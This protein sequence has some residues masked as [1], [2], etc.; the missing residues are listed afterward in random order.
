MAESNHL[1]GSQYTQTTLKEARRI[2]GTTANGMTDESITK[3]VAQIDVL[4][5]I[6]VAQAI[7]SNIK[8]SVD[9][10]KLKLHTDR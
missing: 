9:I 8:S 1:S 10:S 2:L 4:T 6:V 7:G 3:L 5:D